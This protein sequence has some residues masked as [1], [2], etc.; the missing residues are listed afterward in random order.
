MSMPLASLAI[1]PHTKQ[2]TNP[3]Q[4]GSGMFGLFQMSEPNEQT[5]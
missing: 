3:Q 4:G 5:N 2:K 1:K